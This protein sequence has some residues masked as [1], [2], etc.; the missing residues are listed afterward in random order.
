MIAVVNTGG[1]NLASVTNALDRL[2]L[3]W[4]LTADQTKIQ[5]ADRVIL[6]GVGAAKDSMDRLVAA[7]L[8]QVLRGLQR[9][10]L[11]ICLG[12]HLLF[13]D[14]TEGDAKCLGIIPGTVEPIT[15]R[16]GITIPH[17]GW[18]AIERAADDTPLLDGIPNGS[19]F[20]FVH[21]YRAPVGEH[22]CAVADHGEPIPCV[23]ARNNFFGTQFHPE[24]SAEAGARLLEN[25][26]TL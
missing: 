21:S 20:Y 5:Q 19:Y 6:P 15:R 8:P 10:T 18:N 2:Q 16:P 23:V 9:P 22:V 11:G 3:S 25:F 13:D 17:M 26:A 14:S 1:A 12:M 4:E 7:E 24:R